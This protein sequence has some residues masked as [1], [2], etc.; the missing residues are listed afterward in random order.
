MFK[1][2]KQWIAGIAACLISMGAASAQPAGFVA[3]LKAESNFSSWPG[4][5][6]ALKQGLNF[7]PANY[8]ALAGFTVVSDTYNLNYIAYG[9]IRT[10]SLANGMGTLS[11]TIGVGVDSVSNGHEL[12]LRSSAGSRDLDYFDALTR[13]DLNGVAIGD[14]NFVPFGVTPS[15]LQG[16]IAFMRSNMFCALADSPDSPSGVSLGAL[17]SQLDAS[18]MALPDLMPSQFDADAPVIDAFSPA[19]TTLSV[20]EGGSTTVTI[21]VTDPTGNSGPITRQFLDGGNLDVTD[22]GGSTVT[23][24]ATSTLGALPLE[25]VVINSYLQFSSQSIKFTVSE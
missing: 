21:A 22:S 11:V 7:Q 5:G 20:G 16:E 25:L 17:A 6:G 4:Q 23:V 24:S 19:S 9:L 13:G 14:L 12:F 10:L 8:S 18:I 1:I 15:N 3:T 2:E